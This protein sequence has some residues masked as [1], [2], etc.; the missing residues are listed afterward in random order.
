MVHRVVINLDIFSSLPLYQQLAKEVEKAIA[1][2]RL[3]PGEKISSIRELSRQL[4]VSTITVRQ[5]LEKLAA[6]GFLE[7]HHGAGHFVKRDLAWQKENQSLAES[8]EEEVNEESA[9]FTMPT[10]VGASGELDPALP[11]SHEARSLSNALNKYSFHPWWNLKLRYDFRSIGKPVPHFFEG[12][13]WTKLVRDWV[14]EDLSGAGDYGDAQGLLELRVELANWLNRTRNLQ[15]SEAD[16]FISSGAQQCRDLAARVL[17]SRGDKVVLEDPVSITDALAYEAQGANLLHVRQK[18]D[19]IDIDFLQEITDA[20]L[21]HL[22]TTAN[23]PTG[24]S[25]PQE[26]A[27][28]ILKWAEKMDMYLVEDSYGAG[29]LFEGFKPASLYAAAAGKKVRE[30]IIY[31]GSLSQVLSPRLRLG[32]ALVPQGLQKAYLRAKWL[33]DRHPP[34]LTQKLVLRLFREKFM[35]QHHAK[36]QEEAR[37][38]RKQLL[39]ELR[40]WNSELIDFHPVQAGFQQMLVFRESIDDLLVFEKSMAAGVGVIPLSPYCQNDVRTGLVLNYMNL[41]AED[42]AEGMRTLHKVVLDC[43]AQVEP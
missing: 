18:D 3:A 19:G 34:L 21:A 28:Q 32:F 5:A 37:K 15:C 42:I 33:S 7:A 10:F 6:D 35:D 20:K 29:V 36:L 30:R 27:E 13:R 4:Q 2:G 39:E 17:L 22:I 12:K 43:R 24:A 1:E 41:A 25:L 8:K 16:L 40:T 23:F 14:D 38:R 11:W 31:H 9:S 26:R